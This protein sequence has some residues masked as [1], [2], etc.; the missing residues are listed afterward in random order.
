MIIDLGVI[1]HQKGVEIASTFP[2]SPKISQMPGGC[3]VVWTPAAGFVWTDVK[4]LSCFI[5]WSAVGV[6]VTGRRSVH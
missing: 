5:S 1:R 6:C 4:R 3:E 2:K